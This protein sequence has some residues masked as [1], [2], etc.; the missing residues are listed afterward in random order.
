MSNPYKDLN[1]HIKDFFRELD[2]TYDVWCF[3]MMLAGYK[4]LKTMKKSLPHKYFQEY[5]YIPHAEGIKKRDDAY[6]LS[7]E[8]PKLYASLVKT[9]REM[10]IQQDQATKNTIWDHL[11]VL[12]VLNEKCIE[13]R[14]QKHLP[15]IETLE[16]AVCD[17]Q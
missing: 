1:K 6:M 5:V 7:Y 2:K 3:K 12:L 14:K 4:I 16:D 11:N 9:L 17:D 10:W 15:P 13:Y 8:P